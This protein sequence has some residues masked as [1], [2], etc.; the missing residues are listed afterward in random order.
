M[1]PIKFEEQLKDK[2]EQRSLKPSDTAWDK[3]NKGLDAHESGKR[4]NGFWWL[5]IAASTIIVL[6]VIAAVF[7]KKDFVVE[8]KL[9]D[10]ET[11]I[12][13]IPKKE[14]S[15]IVITDTN[16]ENESAAKKNKKVNKQNIIVKSESLKFTENEQQ[17]FEPQK[18]Q[19]VA[20]S[21]NVKET[22]VKKALSFEEQKLREVVAKI[23]TMKT[24]N[25]TV[26]EEE[27]EALLNSAQKEIAL[28]KAKNQSTTV[29]ADVLL[30]EVED[31]LGRS[32]RQRVFD[33][34]LNGYE[35]V[36]TAVAERNN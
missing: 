7:N 23:N 2:L 8:P 9:V 6:F 30:R 10:T 33:V 5:G 22:V 18:T 17:N 14:S 25:K 29:D 36:K 12:N 4:S 20:E 34:L 26:T 11:P 19:A 27:V 35:N 32:F 31:D 1:A 21:N 15:E 28:N 24:E 13:N 3:L 16:S